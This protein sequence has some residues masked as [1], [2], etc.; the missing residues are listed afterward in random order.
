MCRRASFCDLLLANQMSME[1]PATIYN[2]KTS[3]YV[4]SKS[5]ENYASPWKA[6]VIYKYE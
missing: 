5:A 3:E 2:R 1:P 6:N 4:G